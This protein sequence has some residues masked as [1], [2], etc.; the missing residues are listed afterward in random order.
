MID[1]ALVIAAAA[2]AVALFAV[3]AAQGRSKNLKRRV[4]AVEEGLRQI[5]DQFQGLS[6][7]AV[8]QG[9]QLI[10]MEQ[11]LGRLRERLKEVAE[12]ETGGEAFN[13]AIRMARKGATAN[14]I[15]E[16][17]SLS[18]VEADLVILLHRGQ[19]GGFE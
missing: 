18:Q 19:D 1:P 4:D 6:A 3:F 9:Q 10:R 17:C 12:R 15:M 13:Q 8:G 5:H 11:A 14:E 16:N 2:L 7:G